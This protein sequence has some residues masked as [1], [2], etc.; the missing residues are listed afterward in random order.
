MT[1][2]PV[3]RTTAVRAADVLLA[4]GAFLAGA[5]RPLLEWEADGGVP[6]LLLAYLVLGGAACTALVLR[7][8]RPRTV[9]AAT[10]AASA[11]LLAA[12]V[13]WVG[14]I[15]PAAIAIYTATSQL[16]RPGAVWAA[17]SSIAALVCASIVPA[18]WLHREPETVPVALMAAAAGAFGDAARNRREYLAAAVERAERAEQS[19]DE[20]A[21]RRV[22]EDRLAIARELHDIIAHHVAVVNIQTAAA[23]SLIGS[24]PAGARAALEQAGRSAQT[25][26]RDMGSM[27]GALRSADSP[28]ELEPA[29]A[30][31]EAPGL[32][33]LDDLAASFRDLG[34]DCTVTR[35]GP[36]G[37]LTPDHRFVLYRAAQEALANAAKHAP[38]APVVVRLTGG[39]RGVELL[40]ENGPAPAG[41]PHA[42]RNSAVGTGHGLG[43]L[44]ERAS[45]LGGRTSTG[46]TTNGG[47]RVRVWLPRGM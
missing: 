29:R 40:V 41:A 6:A 37:G 11:A 3:P 21:R 46:T 42:P 8:A 26:L 34:M 38:G 14:A 20:E 31:E 44:R 45:A 25:V 30:A 28:V 24:D 2:P 17:V 32:G 1:A 9:L 4:A 16:R 47:F 12:G 10:T 23:R 13:G 15:L 22:A 43:G 33:G 39:D 5:I 35:E 27:L 18:L 19:R 36:L 7:T